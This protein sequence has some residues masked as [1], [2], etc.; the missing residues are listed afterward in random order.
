MSVAFAG[1][2]TV[3][4]VTPKQSV[5]AEVRRTGRRDVAMRC[6]AILEGRRP[7]G[8]FLYVLAGP[9][10]GPVLDGQA[11]GLGGYWPKVWALRGL[12]YA[13]DDAAKQLVADA[14]ADDAWRVREMAAKVI[15]VHE[16]DDAL[17]ALG[18]LVDDP[19]PRVRVAATAAR[20]ALTRAG[21]PA[22]RGVRR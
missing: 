9:P 17:E 4:G 2:A 21:A 19:V 5:L 14:T 1:V 13:W 15:R 22:G 11:G 20:V 16:I 3:W 10:S 7:E 18:R 8:A 12:R 6:V